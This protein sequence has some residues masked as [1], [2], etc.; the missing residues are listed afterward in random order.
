MNAE[1]QTK[2]IQEYNPLEVALSALQLRYAE[3]TVWVVDTPDRMAA[4]KKARAEARTLRIQVEQVRKTAK[5]DAL[6][7]GRRVDSEAKRLT[8][9][10]SK[11]E[12]PAD[13]AI[14][15]VELAKQREIE[16]HEKAE[17][18]RKMKIQA[19][20]DRL[21]NLPIAL[22][23]A[24]PEA[25]TTAAEVLKVLDLS[26]MDHYA[27]VSDAAKEDTLAKLRMMYTGA[28]ARAE[29]QACLAAER[30]ELDRRR[31]EE[32]AARAKH[33]AEDRARREAV[34]AEERQVRERIADQERV[35]REARDKA[36]NE[37]RAARL[38]EQA[39]LDA[40]RDQ[41]EKAKRKAEAEAEEAKRAKLRAEAALFDGRAMLK[42]FIQRFGEVEEFATVAKAI[43]VYLVTHKDG[44]R[45]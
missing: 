44:H 37:A 41:A 36:D 1:N 10:V 21:R 27:D 22:I 12:D 11:I 13:A 26:W 6:E 40:E 8:V 9:A 28:K 4:A 24:S 17:V 15:A 14:K 5:A 7:Y 3:T 32:D 35:A 29:E 43:K 25:I 18:E 20:F 31:T 42:A 45:R 33:E 19:E 2:A 30:A 16:A 39:R 34:D 23:G 38:A